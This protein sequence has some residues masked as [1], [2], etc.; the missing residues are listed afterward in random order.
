M[1]QEGCQSNESPEEKKSPP[2]KTCCSY[3]LLQGDSASAALAWARDT[4]GVLEPEMQQLVK[5]A[6]DASRTPPAGVGMHGL[7]SRP[8]VC[9][10]VWLLDFCF[11]LYL[12]QT[13]HNELFAIR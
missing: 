9:R 3:H 7:H 8:R 11:M 5:Q 12:H 2:S 4:P 1:T 6:V 10:H 13:L